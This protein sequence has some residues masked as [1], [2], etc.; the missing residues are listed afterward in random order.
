MIKLD[1]ST[2]NLIRSGGGNGDRLDLAAIQH[3]ISSTQTL[4]YSHIEHRLSSA[5]GR[6]LSLDASNDS[7]GARVDFTALAGQANAVNEKIEIFNDYAP[8]A[9]VGDEV[10]NGISH[11]TVSGI[12]SSGYLDTGLQSVIGKAATSTAAA[13]ADG[14]VTEADITPVS[15]SRLPLCTVDRVR[16]SDLTVEAFQR[17][18]VALNKPLIIETDGSSAAVDNESSGES[19][20]PAGLYRVCDGIIDVEASAYGV[21]PTLFSC[22]YTHSLASGQSGCEIR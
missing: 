10:S 20:V 14:T 2:G 5:Y 17:D 19:N 18:Y 11:S 6:V 7:D 15:D 8:S 16:L 9:V 22:A 1:S 12:G 13:A 4:Q 21:S 3:A